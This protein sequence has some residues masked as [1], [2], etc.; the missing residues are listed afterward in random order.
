MIADLLVTRCLPVLCR[1][2]LCASLRQ[3][4]AI[5]QEF[6]MCDWIVVRKGHCTI[7]LSFRIIH[8]AGES[9]AIG[10]CKMVHIT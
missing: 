6:A 5:P 8:E 3:V 2:E 9:S 4:I 1:D 10:N 7:T